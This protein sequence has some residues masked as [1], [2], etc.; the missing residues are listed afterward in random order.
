MSDGE[1]A[2]IEKINH[3]KNEETVYNF[4]VDNN[5]NYFVDK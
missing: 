3:Y 4:E 2:K 5:H 1:L